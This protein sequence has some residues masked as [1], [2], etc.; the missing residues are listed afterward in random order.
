MSIK[1]YDI[2]KGSS[3]LVVHNGVAYFTGHASPR[4]Q[5]LREQTAGVCRRYDELFAQFGL[6]KENIIMMNAY[7][8]DINE[9]PEFDEE[10]NKWVGEEH[11]PAGVAVQASPVQNSA[12]GDNIRLELALIVAVDED[13]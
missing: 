5:T 13:K 1:R 3:R 9:L 8:K 6:K 2:N 12:M 7:L 10:W 11:A 4:Y